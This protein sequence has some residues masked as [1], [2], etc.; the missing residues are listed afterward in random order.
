MW[1][2]APASN[3]LVI[4]AIGASAGGLE[5]MSPLFAQIKP[6]GRIAYIV[7]Q[8]MAKDGHDELLV[9]LIQRESALP[10]ILATSGVHLQADTVYVIPSGHDGMLKGDTLL[11]ASPAPEN[12]STPSVNTLFAS[13]AQNCRTQAISI[14]LSGT[15][16]DGMTGSRAVMKNGGLTIAQDPQ[17][18]RFNGMPLAAIEARTIDQVL[19]IT[20]IAALLASRFPGTPANNINVPGTFVIKP[21][22]IAKSV[23]AASDNPELRTLLRQVHEAT[24]IDF[25]S[26]KEETLMR[27]L[28]KRKAVIGIHSA[29]DYQARIR[30]DPDELHVLQH[31]FLVSVSSFFRD[32]ESFSELERSLATLLAGKTRSEEIRIWVAGCASGEEP[33]TLAIILHELL[34]QSLHV[35][36][37]SITATDLNPEALAIARAGIY[38][39]T[40]FK[41]M[42]DTLRER[43]FVR[44]GQHFVI[45][46]QLRASVQFEQRDVLTGVSVKGLD[47]IS[48]RNLLIYMKS[49]LQDQLIKHFHQALRPGGLLFIGQ[50]ESLSFIGNSLFAAVDHYHRLFRRRH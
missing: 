4:A 31:L 42:S 29:E 17:E 20:G 1:H 9:R 18:A 48:C 43:Y 40:A 44:Q 30:H 12:L 47:L 33:Y 45:N 46:D 5:A 32:R 11:L 28:E 6:N 36:R 25:S 21:V 34:G 13:L 49:P 26:Y 14:L 24:G 3:P 8:H 19:P 15:G 7:A 50:S 27:R 22:T 35:Q 16:A 41:E 2:P 10:V 37:F 23:T 39:Q 38:R